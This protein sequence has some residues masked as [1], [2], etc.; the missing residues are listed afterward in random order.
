VKKKGNFEGNKTKEKQ[1]SNELRYT[2][3]K[4]P[5]KEM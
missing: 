5:N 1:R 3:K 2:D 4:E